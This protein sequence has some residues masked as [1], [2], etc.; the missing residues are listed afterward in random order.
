MTNPD[1]KSKIYTGVGDSGTTRLVDGSCVE[2]FNPRVEAYGTVDELNS[3]LGLIRSLLLHDN[4]KNNLTYSFLEK[5]QNHLFRIGSLIATSDDKV[6]ASLPQIEKTHVIFLEKTIDE[7]DQEIPKL[8]QFILPSGSIESSHLHI[9][10]TLCRRAERRTSEVIIKG[11]YEANSLSLVL[12]Y[13]NRLSDLLFVTARWLNLKKG[14][15]DVTW[16]KDI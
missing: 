4:L 1:K 8:T 14:Y 3:Y 16:N 2:K 13:L 11:N 9:A 6:L 12:I 7:L 10:R 15:P 5:I